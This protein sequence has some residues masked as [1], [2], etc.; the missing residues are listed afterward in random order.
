MNL[1]RD[2][3]QIYTA[4]GIG[5][6]LLWGLL[7]FTTGRFNFLYLEQW[8]T[9]INDAS[10]L[11]NEVMQPGGLAQLIADLLLQF[12]CYPA[13]GILLTAL[14]FT[15]L[16]LLTARLFYQWAHTPL[17]LPL[18]LFP[19]AA[20]LFLHHNVN[21][22]YSGTVA[23]LLMLLLLAGHAYIRTHRM[24]LLYSL[25]ATALLYTLAGPVTS[26]FTL[27]LVL[28]AV[29]EWRRASLYYLLPP[30]LLLLLGWLSLRAGLSGTWQHLLLPDGYFTHRLQAA[31]VIYL[32]WCLLI[33]VSL[34]ALLSRR[35]T[36]SHRM[37]RGAVLLLQ[38]VGLTVFFV[39]G[40]HRYIDSR[41]EVFKELNCHA[42]EGRWDLLRQRG[43]TLPLNNLLFQNYYHVA[44][45]EEGVLADRLFHSPCIDIQSIYVQGDKTPY[46][47]ALLSD[48]YFSMGHIALSQRYAFEANEAMGNH[49]PRLLQRLVQTNLIYGAYDVAAK[50]ITLLEHTLCYRQWAARHRHYL[51]N[52]AAVETDPL[53]G[54]KRRCLFPDNRFSGSKGLDDDLKQILHSHPSHRIT[55][56][57]LGSLYLLSKD[58]PRFQQTLET[59]YGTP[60]L[61]EGSLPVHFQEGVMAFA[62]NQPQLLEHYQITA[63]V[64]QRYEAFLQNPS[65]G[66]NTV[67][68]FLQFA[69]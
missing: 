67:W 22:F 59:F 46:V 58:L 61:P 50:Y 16:S 42:R 28:Q 56:Q 43:N 3:Q 52:D 20:L 32:P 51:W 25:L 53:L 30:L 33:A 31:S 35:F 66:R 6:F 14:L 62:A 7:L 8:R 69:R 38:V 60:S 1:L 49:S 44:L 57:Y 48:I 47:S 40:S 45:A 12:F 13:V 36:L 29:A 15:L 21:Y 39:D 54:N 4:V 55:L 37:L 68:Y 18:S 17:V 9:F 65:S 5:L 27:L 10:T 26:L 23:L 11:R 41:N 19:V 63:D 64:R 24:R 34:L 2:R